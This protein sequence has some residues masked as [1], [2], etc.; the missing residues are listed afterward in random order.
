V[1]E[2][3]GSIGGWRQGEAI[4]PRYVVYYQWYMRTNPDDSRF[5][6]MVIFM[7]VALFTDC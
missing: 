1:T 5:L 7:K 2:D 3:A 6:G 4:L